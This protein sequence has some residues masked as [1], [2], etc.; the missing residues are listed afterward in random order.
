MFASLPGTATGTL[1]IAGS[2]DNFVTDNTGFLP[3]TD[4]Q[5]FQGKRYFKFQVALQ[6]DS[7]S[8]PASTASNVTQVTASYVNYQEKNFQF[9]QACGYIAGGPPEGLILLSLFGLIYFLTSGRL[10]RK[11]LSLIPR[12][13]RL[14]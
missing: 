2:A 12:P 13:T 9:T 11:I 6:Q 8:A 4:V 10:R 5:A 1:L 7:T 3:A 14:S